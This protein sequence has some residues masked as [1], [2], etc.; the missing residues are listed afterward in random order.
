MCGEDVERFT[1][2][3]EAGDVDGVVALM[4]DDVWMAMPPMPLEYQ[5]RALAAQ[6]LT[7]IRRGRSFRLVATRAN[8][9]PA[10]GVYLYD[11]ETGLAHANGM[12]VLTSTSNISIR[13]P[14]SCPKTSSAERALAS[15]ALR[16]SSSVFSIAVLLRH[17]IVYN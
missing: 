16:W 14:A 4:T 10:F 6:F 8:G 3:F 1:L 13:V 9:Q 7:T 12:F 15:R 2:A 11:Q 17:Q 5:G